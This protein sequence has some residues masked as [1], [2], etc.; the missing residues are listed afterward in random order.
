MAATY[1][2]CPTSSDSVNLSFSDADIFART[3]D[4]RSEI[5]DLHVLALTEG[6]HDVVAFADLRDYGLIS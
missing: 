3:T 6:A 2:I 1:F 5:P 4:M